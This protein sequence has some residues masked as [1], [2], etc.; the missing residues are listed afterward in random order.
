[1]NR[2]SVITAISLAL[3][4]SAVIVLFLGYHWV[5]AGLVVAALV[6]NFPVL[7]FPNGAY[8]AV[9]FINATVAGFVFEAISLPTAWGLLAASTFVATTSLNVRLLFYKNLNRSSF[10]FLEFGLAG[11]SFG[12]YLAANL[13]V[14]GQ[15]YQWAFPAVPILLQ[16]AHASNIFMDYGKLL[17]NARGGYGIRPGDMAPDFELTNEEGIAMRLSD[18]RG[19]RH[20]LI[21][22]F[23]GDWCPYC[24]I[25]LRTYGKESP[26]FQAKNILLLAI[27]PDDPDTNRLLVE[28]LKLD[29]HVLSDEKLET[30]RQYGIRMEGYAPV[31]RVKYNDNSPLPASFLVDKE[32][33]LRFTSHPERVGE[34]LNPALI[35]PV[36]DQLN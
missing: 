6:S 21:V 10:R 11:V 7:L 12:L 18:F 15:W 22:F 14:Y 36:V 13:T 35:F 20:V 8:F 30:V 34:Y 2:T 4:A 17:K 32:G 29:F 31:N 23:R 9:P 33:I 26:K 25:M 24:N 19:K 5:A 1:M 3:S 28:Q 16:L 27:G